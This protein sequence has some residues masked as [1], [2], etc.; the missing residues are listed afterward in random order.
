MHF[1]IDYLRNFIQKNYNSKCYILILCFLSFA[2]VV[3]Y[4]VDLEIN[5][6]DKEKSEFLRPVYYILLYGIAYYGTLL[7][8]YIVK[9][10]NFFSKKIFYRSA[11]ILIILG[12]YTGF[13]G[14]IKWLNIYFK[15]PQHYILKLT[16][17]QLFQLL[18][19]L[20][21]AFC[22]VSVYKL[23]SH[24]FGLLNFH[25]HWRIYIYLFIGSICITFS[26]SFL[27]DFIHHYPTYKANISAQYYQLPEWIFLLGYELA[28]GSSFI[29]VELIFRG[30]MVVWMMEYL[31]DEA[32]IAMAVSYCFLH[33]G[34]PIGETISSFFGGYLLGVIT[35]YS[36]SIFA[37]V[38][39]HITLAWSMELFSFWQK[40]F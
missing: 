1:L 23:K 2:V 12:I 31:D 9:G 40:G 33:F 4:S 30:L 26:A 22:I 28:Y 24:F 3:N 8:V 36:K 25:T 21:G 38:I 14:H 13:L 19:V 32:V 39:I 37:G 11:I 34:K 18:I 17:H 10:K 29:A 27:D 6:I 7:I 15:M 35:Y 5:I 20:I 16:V